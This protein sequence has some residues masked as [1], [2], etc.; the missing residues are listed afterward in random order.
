MASH[1]G[2]TPTQKRILDEI[3]CGNSL[4]FAPR[5]TIEN[6]VALGMLQRLPDKQL[7]RDRFGAVKMPQ[8]EMTI[9]T[10]MAWCEFQSEQHEKDHIN[11]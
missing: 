7:G 5:K 8:F 9:S 1:P 3:G 2:R 10:H 4:P 6:M 11:D